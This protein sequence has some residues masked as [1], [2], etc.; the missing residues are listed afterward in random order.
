[1]TKHAVIGLGFIYNKHAEA[2]SNTGGEIVI[3][4]DIDKSKKDKLPEGSK[5]TEE[6]TDI[7][8][9]DYVS[10]LT[11]NYQHPL[12][13]KHFTEKGI[14]VLCEKPPVIS[15]KDYYD[16]K[17]EDIDVVLQLRHHPEI[18]KWK[19]EI[20][21]Y[22]DYKVDM[23]ILVR[24]DQWY[25]DS[26]KGDEMK[27]GGLLF[28]IGIHYFDALAHLFGPFIEVK[29]EYIRAK[30]AKGKIRFLNAY[31]NWELALD[32]PMDN[33]K[34]IFEINRNKLNLSQGFEN[35]HTKVYE[36]MLEGRGIKLDECGETIKLIE[37]IKDNA[38]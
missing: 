30:R 7:K 5:F 37:K 34:R 20:K 21:E 28:N 19:D 29:T 1:M 33:Q 10:I 35:L 32:A 38:I 18:K 8:D 4:C 25:F 24:R 23:K 13:V 31:V 27:S 15:S 36:E 11:P 16:L 14:K 9:V 22:E 2:I 26:W 3:G 6:W 17:D 12:M